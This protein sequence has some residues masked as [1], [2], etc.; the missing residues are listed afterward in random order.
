MLPTILVTGG[1]GYIGSHTCKALSEA[2]WLPVAY[3]DL[4]NGH[5]W[6]VRWG[7]LEVGDIRDRDR[8]IEVIRRHNPVG[9]LHFAG[10]IEAGLSVTEPMRFYDVNVRGTMALLEAIMATAPIPL[11]FSS[12]AAVYGTLERSPA[13]ETHPLAPVSP[14]GRSKLMVEQMIT[15]LAHA[16]G[17]NWTALRYF[18][19]AG[20]DPEGE[21]GEAHQPETHLIPLA[22]E[23]AVGRRSA[24]TLFGK[25]YDTP[26]GT[27][28]RDFIH[29]AD[30]ARAHVL[31]LGRLLHGGW[32]TALN[33]GTG[34][35]YSVRQV[36]KAVEEVSGRKVPVLVRDR[37]PGDPPSLVSNS[38]RAHKVLGWAPIRSGLDDIVAD[39]WNWNSR[40]FEIKEA[41]HALG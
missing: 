30:L 15:D 13:D 37:R 41:R 36:I 29:V 33:L 28:V 21:L 3:D 8:L 19:A 17:L 6:A 4:S 31:A 14:Y 35:G 23:V 38:D 34:R 39:A 27:C 10:L 12:T 7:P 2:G 22:I 16:K 1:A 25:D 18:N 32:S 24:F 40:H 20:A 11:V 5:D 26:D 9:I